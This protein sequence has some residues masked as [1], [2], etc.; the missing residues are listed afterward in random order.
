MSDVEGLTKELDDA[1][2][3]KSS[4][5]RKVNKIK[6]DSEK[7]I[8]ALKE[9]IAKLKEENS[10]AQADEA[11]KKELDSLKKE[12]AALKAQVNTKAK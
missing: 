10:K 6:S 11:L 12:F 1:K 5:E 3:A 4:L 8:K 9:E 2:R 7:E